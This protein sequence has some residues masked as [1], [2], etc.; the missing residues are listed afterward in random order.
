MPH[1]ALPEKWCRTAVSP[2]DDSLARELEQEQH[3]T[4]EQ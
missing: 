2:M 1:I 4:G 3:G